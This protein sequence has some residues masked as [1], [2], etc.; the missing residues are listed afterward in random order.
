MFCMLLSF[1]NYLRKICTNEL[2]KSFFKKILEKYENMGKT[3][4]KSVIYIMS[5]GNT[6]K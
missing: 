2:F 6:L 1:F 3:G 5:V 4:K